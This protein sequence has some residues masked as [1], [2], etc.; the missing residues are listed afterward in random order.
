MR[1]LPVRSLRVDVLEG[2]DAGRSFVASAETLT[3]GT[4]NNN[5]V[6]LTDPTVSRYH[7]ELARHATG[8]AVVDHA[9]T[10]GTFVGA[11]RVERAVAPAGTII[12]VGRTSLRVSEGADVAIDLHGDERLA[13]LRGKTLVM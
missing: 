4:A 6:V 12:S 9:S 10:N 7:V 8:V 3:V 5:D 13:G 2:P 1:Y 11:V